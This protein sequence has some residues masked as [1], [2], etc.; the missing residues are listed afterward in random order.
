M[1]STNNSYVGAA[2]SG[3]VGLLGRTGLPPDPVGFQLGTGCLPPSIMSPTA[4]TS[5]SAAAPTSSRSR[6]F[7]HCTARWASRSAWAFSRAASRCPVSAARW[8]AAC[9]ARTEFC[10][11]AVVGLHGKTLVGALQLGSGRVGTGLR[12][13][14]IGDR[15][16]AVS[17]FALLGLSLLSWPSAVDDSLPVTA[18]AVRLALHRIDQTL[19]CLGSLLVFSHLCL[20]WIAWLDRR[21]FGVARRQVARREAAPA[22]RHWS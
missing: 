17:L 19:A 18:P 1:I 21:V 7:A 3:Q 13:L 4:S 20:L 14:G 22:V 9:S 2:A 11:A 5:S 10:T 6:A 12:S 8:S 16:N 15:L